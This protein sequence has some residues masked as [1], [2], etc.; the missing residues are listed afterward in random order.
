MDSLK[1][2]SAILQ[3]SDHLKD[4]F[5]HNLQRFR[6]DTEIHKKIYCITTDN[7]ANMIK[8]DKL[9]N[10]IYT[11]QAGP[12]SENTDICQLNLSY[13]KY[14]NSDCYDDVEEIYTTQITQ[15]F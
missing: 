5:V 13:L 8:M 11:A 12:S 15:I 3:S 9:V 7:G 1:L 4:L 14:E 6:I 2:F 10:E